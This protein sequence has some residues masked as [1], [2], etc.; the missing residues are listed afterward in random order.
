[1]KD[2]RTYFDSHASSWDEKLK[3]HERSSELMEVVS[4]FELEEGHWVLDVGTGTGI[5][6][7]WIQK[8]IGPKGILIGLDFSLKMIEKAK[9]REDRERRILLT[10]DVE[11]LPLQPDLFDRVTCFSAFPHFSDKLKALFEMVRVL[12]QGGLLFI[13]H[14]KSVEELNQFHKTLGE[15]VSND[16][17]PS[18]EVLRNMMRSVGLLEVNII[19]QPGKFLARG[20][21]S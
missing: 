5:L 10:A 16:L 9:L 19:N 12:K 7:P 8:I 20:R 4:W 3:Y 21:K 13:A 15:P 2:L 11:F 18:P 1:M 6:L 17:L 14:L